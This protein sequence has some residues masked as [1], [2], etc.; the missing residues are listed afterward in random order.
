MARPAVVRSLP[1]Q[2]ATAYSL[3]TQQLRDEI[4]AGHY[5]P[6]VALP[7]EAELCEAHG[8]S[9]QTVRR[10]F[11]DLVAEGIVFRVPGKGTF[12][13]NTQGKY[14]R[15][16]G[17]IE[18][19]MSLAVDT[20]LEVLSPPQ[21]VI[22]INAAGR[23]HLDTDQLVSMRFRRLHHDRPYCVTTAYCPMSW[24]VRLQE[25]AEFR[26][27]GVRRNM[28]VLSVVQ[29]VAG[30]PIAGGDQTITAVAAD[31]GTAALLECAPGDPLLR[32]DRLYF[33]PSGDFIE[34]AIN[35][36]NPARYTYR[37]QMRANQT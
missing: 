30:R 29:R 17:S 24:G 31:E 2:H 14:I 4:T 3:I 23:L 1:R 35:H 27:V 33:D 9:R 18:D 34:L 16:S 13:S 8:V 11:Q 21:I 7:T 20:D 37:F 19:L 22:D 5:P 25:V 6:G 10:A 26:S 12:V 28:T 36:F 32:I 15:S